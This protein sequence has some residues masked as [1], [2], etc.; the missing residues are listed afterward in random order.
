MGIRP[1]IKRMI[2]VLIC[3]VLVSSFAGTPQGA[4]SWVRV[5]V[6][7]KS[8]EAAVAAVRASDGVVLSEISIINSVVARVSASSIA[9]LERAPGV[10]QVTPDR[11]VNRAGK[12]VDVEFVKA[13]GAQQV[14]ETGILGQGVTIAVLDSGIDAQFSELNQLP[15]GKGKGERFLAYY[16]AIDQK[17]YEANKLQK[18][19]RDPSGHGTHVAGIIGNAQYEP[20]DNEYRG[21]APSVNL[22]AV[23]V[24]DETGVGTYADVLRGIE[25]VVKNK[26]TYNIRVLNISMYAPVYAP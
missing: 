15:E 2:V 5:I 1:S 22:V 3:L 21:V 7:G 12:K 14:W 16:D 6:Q 9:D 24:L 23:R 4:A 20:D 26:D 18:S 13:I 19:P 8:L 10:V 25:W 11:S 17:L